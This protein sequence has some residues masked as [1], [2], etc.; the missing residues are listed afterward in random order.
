M[1][2]ER[3]QSHGQVQVATL[4]IIDLNVFSSSISD[5]YVKVAKKAQKINSIPIN[6]FDRL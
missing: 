1:Q 3:V 2:V 5:N 6:L 4:E